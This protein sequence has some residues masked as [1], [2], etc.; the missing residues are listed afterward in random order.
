MGEGSVASLIDEEDDDLLLVFERASRSLVAW[1]D[2]RT[3]WRGWLNG[4]SKTTD[5]KGRVVG[6]EESVKG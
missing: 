2:H 6:L 3:E 4:R 5:R 1:S